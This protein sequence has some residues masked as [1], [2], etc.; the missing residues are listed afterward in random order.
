LHQVQDIFLPPSSDLH[1]PYHY[2]YTVHNGQQGL[3]K[4]DL[5]RKKYIKAVDLTKY[6]CVPTNVAY[7]SLGNFTCLCFYFCS[8]S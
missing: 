8:F 3:F 7:V 4:V 2:G 1:H 6:N 5:E